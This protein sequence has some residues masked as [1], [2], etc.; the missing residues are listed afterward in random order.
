MRHPAVK[1]FQ[2]T[3]P[4]RRRLNTIPDFAPGLYLFQSTP[5]RRRRPCC[6]G[7]ENE[8]VLFQSTPPRRRRQTR[9]QHFKNQTDY[10]NPR[11][12][13]GG[14]HLIQRFSH[15]YH[16]FNPRLREG[17]DEIRFRSDQNH[18]ISI[19]ASAKE[20]TYHALCLYLWNNVISIHA[21]AKEATKY[22][23]S[24]KTYK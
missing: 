23:S 2:S 21:S 8:T 18:T 4:R 1:K 15:H 22:D 5:P 24:N 13:E 7:C 9:R 3:P 6:G 12:C 17:G 14:D 19:H 20:A 16:Y 10:F 11:L